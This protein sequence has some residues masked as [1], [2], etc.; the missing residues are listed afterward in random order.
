MLMT[1]LSLVRCKALPIEDGYRL[2][3]EVDGDFV[4]WLCQHTHQTVCAAERCP[5]ALAD[6]LRHGP[7]SSDFTCPDK[8]AR[9]E[10]SDE[11]NPHE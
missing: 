7:M 4:D 5:E 11:T 3:V 6:R 2:G 8:G 1:Q 9:T 10:R